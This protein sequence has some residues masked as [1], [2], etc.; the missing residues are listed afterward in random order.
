MKGREARVL[1]PAL[2][3]GIFLLGYLL[4]SN[5]YYSNN[6]REVDEKKLPDFYFQGST[7]FVLIAL[8]SIE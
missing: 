5:F 4:T 3:I 1:F 7:Q 8:I 2:F 6:Y